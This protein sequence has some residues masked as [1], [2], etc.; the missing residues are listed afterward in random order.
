MESKNIRRILFN[1]LKQKKEGNSLMLKNLKNLKNLHI[2]LPMITNNQTEIGTST[3]Y[4]ENI[5]KQIH[6]VKIN[7]NEK[8]KEL[9]FLKIQY[10]KLIK[11]N[12]GYKKLIYEV[13]DLHD[14]AKNNI[15]RNE[16]KEIFLDS[17]Y[18]SEEQLLNKINE[19]K[20]DK[21]QKNELIKSFEILN[22]KDQLN[23]KRKLLLNKKKE[24]DELKHGT[25]V[26]NIFEMNSKLETIRVNGKRLQNEVSSLE[27]THTKKE[28]IISKLEKDIKNEEKENEK[29]NKQLSEYE[30][31]YNNKLKEMKEIEKDLNDIDI[32]RKIQ[33]NKMTNNTQYEGS[34]LKGLKLKSKIVKIRNDIDKLEK[35]ETEKRGDL[36]NLLEQRRKIVTDLRN[37]CIELE[38]KIYDLEQKNNKLFTQVKINEQ[39][40]IA[41]EN[42][43]KEQIKDIKR[44]KELEKVIFELKLTKEQIIKELEEKQKYLNNIKNGNDKKNNI[45]EIKEVKENEKTRSRNEN[46]NDNLK[47]LENQENKDKN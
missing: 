45:E 2:K 47:S 46:Q 5:R 31:K 34:K 1:S 19:C 4:I 12:R 10:N 18:I 24:F 33:I 37:K 43:G 6:Q 41:F 20:I 36:K 42:R 22:L 44:L 30:T 11:E 40:K 14:E 9:Q 15:E 16:N 28:E 17:S 38:N 32:R 35:Y 39:E 25:S 26:K 27:G 13:L 29:Y 3:K 8:K 21:K 7:V 23:I